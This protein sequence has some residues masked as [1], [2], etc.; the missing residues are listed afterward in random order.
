MTATIEAPTTTRPEQRPLFV[1]SNAPAPANGESTRGAGGSSLAGHTPAAPEIHKELA[2]EQKVLT[3]EDFNLWYGR[4][5][6]LHNISMGI[7]AGKVT[8]LVGPSGCGKS[9]LLRSMNRL[10]DLVDG[11]RITGNMAFKGEAIYGRHT[12]VIA[13]RQRLGM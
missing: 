12:D 6:A 1:G 3:V 2:G 9:T 13:L 8:A 11:V 10:N 5:Q 4:T 7:P